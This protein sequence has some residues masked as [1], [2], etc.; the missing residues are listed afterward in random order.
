MHRNHVHAKH[1]GIYIFTLT[2]SITP[3]YTYIRPTDRQMY[4][5]TYVPAYIDRTF[6]WGFCCCI[7]FWFG[8][9]LGFWTFAL[10]FFGAW[11]FALTCS[12][13]IQLVA[14]FVH[15]LC[16]TF[17]FCV[18]LSLGLF[19]YII[20]L[21]AWTFSWI[22]S[23][24]SGLGWTCSFKLGWTLVFLFDCCL[25]FNFLLE[26][27]F[28]SS[29]LAGAFVLVFVLLYFLGVELVYWRLYFNFCLGLFVDFEVLVGLFGLE[30]SL[31]LL[32]WHSTFFLHCLQPLLEPLL[33]YF[34]FAWIFVGFSIFAWIDDCFRALSFNFEFSLGRNI[35]KSYARYHLP[36]QWRRLPSLLISSQKEKLSHSHQKSVYV[37]PFFG[38]Q[39]DMKRN[40]AKKLMD[41]AIQSRKR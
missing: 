37:A 2:H 11:T 34:S 29:N 20:L 23:W 10:S 1:T 14:F 18:H 17:C 22:F 33:W 25:A 26:L 39:V 3:A 27:L 6:A 40:D 21:M 30:P 31:E 7:Q 12:L 8:L 9:G 38:G 32:S 36:W 13:G 41:Y 28:L 16:L 5:H 15:N 24:R 35:S 19:C 4:M